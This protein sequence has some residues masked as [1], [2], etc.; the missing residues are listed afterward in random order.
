MLTLTYKV[1]AALCGW[2]EAILYA[3]RGAES[4]RGNEHGGMMAQRVAAL[5]LAPVAVWLYT[6]WGW[7]I[8]LEIVPMALFFPAAHDEAY[9]FTRLWLK[10]SE[11][12]AF[13]DWET[14]QLAWKE[15]R[16]GYQSKT[17]TA[18]NDFNGSTRTI[19]AIT[20]AVLLV[21]IYA[22]YFLHFFPS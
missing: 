16:Y 19:L 10:Y 15:Y 11:T 20:G 1:F 2:L 17:T 13:T 4:F 21:A 6:H 12:E 14:C 22:A 8:L 3:K 18:R 7:W 9:N 5:L